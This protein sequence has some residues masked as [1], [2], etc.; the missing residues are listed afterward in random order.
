ME[1]KCVTL[2]SAYHLDSLANGNFEPSHT[3]LLQHE[4]TLMVWPHSI[5]IFPFYLHLIYSDR[6]QLEHVTYSA[7]LEPRGEMCI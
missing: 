5:Q 1:N 4:V 2:G 6:L 3:V 7:C